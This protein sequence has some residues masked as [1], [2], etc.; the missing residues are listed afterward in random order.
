MG[1][2]L[3]GCAAAATLAEQGY[4]V[5]SFCF[6]ESARRAHSIAAQGGVNADKK[7]IKMMATVSPAC[8]EIH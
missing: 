4:Q 5:S 2:G 7:I 6:H 8:L 3:S 1:T